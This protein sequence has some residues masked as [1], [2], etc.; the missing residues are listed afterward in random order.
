[1]LSDI[2]RKRSSG[3][4]KTTICFVMLTLFVSAARKTVRRI[5]HGYECLVFDHF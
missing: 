1:M 2:S 4:S 5:P 3:Y